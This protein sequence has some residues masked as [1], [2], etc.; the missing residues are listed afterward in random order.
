M[1]KKVLRGIAFAIAGLLIG[2][3][4]GGGP[5]LLGWWMG[6]SKETVVRVELKKECYV[7]D[8]N[9]RPMHHWEHYWNGYEMSRVHLGAT[10]PPCTCYRT[11]D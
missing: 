11:F 8:P 1:I 9:P 6:A 4:V 3:A 7:Y 10:C 2:M 5:I